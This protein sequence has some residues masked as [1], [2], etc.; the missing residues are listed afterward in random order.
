MSTQSIEHEQLRLHKNRSILY[1]HIPEYILLLLLSGFT[2]HYA[3]ID[4]LAKH[5]LTK[6][7]SAYAHPF[8]DHM[9]QA[10]SDFG[11]GS[12]GLPNP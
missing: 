4:Q 1:H 11:A 10:E 2:L 12:P 8:S 6:K 3:Y 7:A 9:F 5:S